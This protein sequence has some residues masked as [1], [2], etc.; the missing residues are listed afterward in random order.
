MQN[1]EESASN[2]LWTATREG[3]WGFGTRS[4]LV[5]RP[6]SCGR[7]QAHSDRRDGPVAQL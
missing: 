1:L 5:H 7:R 4:Q 6:E 3:A 2:G